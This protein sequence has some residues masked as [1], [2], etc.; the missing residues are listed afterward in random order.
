MIRESTRQVVESWRGDRRRLAGPRPASTARSRPSRAGAAPRAG[1]RR[2]ARRR[3]PRPGV[4][5]ASRERR[6]RPCARAIALPTH[7]PVPASRLA[8]RPRRAPADQRAPLAG[9]VSVDH[10]SSSDAGEPATIWHRSSQD[11]AWPQR[12]RRIRGADRTASGS[13]AKV[14]TGQAASTASMITSDR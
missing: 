8:P 3:P 10:L 9:A 2:A 1:I 13:S 12:T 7:G 14:A 11:S 5:R 6:P 4:L